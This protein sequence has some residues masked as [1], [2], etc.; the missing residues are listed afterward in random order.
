MKGFYLALFLLSG[1][2]VGAAQSWRFTNIRLPDRIQRSDISGLYHDPIGY[3]WLMHKHGMHRFDG[4]TWQPLQPPGG[5]KAQVTAV[6][7]D[8]QNQLWIG[9]SDGS[10]WASRT[11][12]LEK[13][14]F[15]E[16]HPAK[17]ITGFAEDDLHRIWWST[18]GEGAYVIDQGRQYNFNSE[19]GLPADDV[20]TILSDKKNTWVTTDG[21]VIQLQLEGGKKNVKKL[22]AKAGLS[23]EVVLCMV[24]M[25]TGFLAGTFDQGLFWGNGASFKSFGNNS[26]PWSLGAI[27]AIY[28]QPGER[29]WIG[30]ESQGLWQWDLHWNRL[31]QV[32]GSQDWKGCKV[33]DL[34]ADAE[35]NIWVL[36]DRHGLS[37]VNTQLTQ[38]TTPP[39]N[40]QAL[41]IDGG[42]QI[43][44]GTENGLYKGALNL[45]GTYQWQRQVGVNANITSIWAPD[46]QTLW[47]GTL[48]QGIWKY[49]VVN[50]R[51]QQWNESQGLQRSS[52]LSLQGDGE[53]LWLGALGGLSRTRYQSAPLLFE[54]EKERG[55]PH[56]NYIYHIYKG[57]GGQM[58]FGTDGQGLGIW[59]GKQFTLHKNLGK[60][61]LHSVY[62]IT[63]TS[64]G[65]WWLGTDRN[66][67]VRWD[68]KTAKAW[69]NGQGMSSTTIPSVMADRNGNILA[70]H[71]NGLDLVHPF[72]GQVRSWGPEWGLWE[73]FDPNMNAIFKDAAQRI[74][75]AGNGALYLYT[76][77][78]SMIPGPKLIIESIKFSDKNANWETEHH[79]AA[80]ENNLSLQFIGVWF[81]EPEKVLYRYRLEGFDP[82]WIYT[83]NKQLIYNNLPPG[84]YTLYL[85][86]GLGTSF[87]GAKGF[88]Y[89]F[90]IAAPWYFTWWFWTSLAMLLV[91]LFYW[92][93]TNRDKRLARI[94]RLEKE[95]AERQ[96]QALQSQINP[97]FLFNN[98]N[99]LMALIEEDQ[100]GALEYVEA[101]SDFYRHIL[102]YRDVDLIPLTTELEIVQ[103][104]LNLL[105][106]R[107]G[108]HLQVKVDLKDTGCMV[109]PLA[110][111]ML[112]ENA[113]KHNVVAA[114]QPLQVEIFRANGHL[115][116]QNNLQPKISTAPSTAFGLQG[117]KQR[118]ELLGKAVVVEKTATKFKVLLPCIETD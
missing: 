21:G 29:I 46:D 45:D 12:G 44:L 47:L 104:F 72:S 79:F 59:D 85:E 1:W 71:R 55:I 57:T 9:L 31:F 5:W 96:L 74:W 84:L 67:L 80:S 18:Y 53:W 48:G 38:Y 99:T 108:G 81:T 116:V 93:Q 49:H 14:E 43:W 115:V 52:L 25:G 36:S 92:Y 39:E 15:E 66:G 101:L 91:L 109:V 56:A 117:I 95:K 50:N 51:Y 114:S 64:D 10:L 62:S 26:N 61:N 20:Y 94:N 77:I 2:V 118:Y 6:F 70:L 112:L 58:A 107:Y 54:T 35:G 28:H 106:K 105:G 113:V 75:F 68:G 100:Q 40:V 33:Y 37:R 7:R 97:H 88:K 78:H 8:W 16:G 22:G 69:T 102:Q 23:D 41:K 4:H 110:L 17:P 65:V 19:D 32:G 13:L 34:E 42:G 3:I 27:T 11:N 30:T 76:G 63:Q 82:D 24:P 60:L 73:E 90:R 89:T 87:T 111:Q 86:A 103:G 98:F 83:A